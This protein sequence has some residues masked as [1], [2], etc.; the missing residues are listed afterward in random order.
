M[1]AVR[2]DT[3]IVSSF[4]ATYVGSFHDNNDCQQYKS[5]RQ[6]EKRQTTEEMLLDVKCEEIIFFTMYLDNTYP[7]DFPG[8]PYSSH[9][10]I[11][12]R[13][14]VEYCQCL[15]KRWKGREWNSN[16]FRG[17]PVEGFNEG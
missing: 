5:R 3:I 4:T 12:L 10:C 9:A 14:L 13:Q 11:Q 16:Q 7:A 8:E 1:L 2:R 15:M 6:G 17:V